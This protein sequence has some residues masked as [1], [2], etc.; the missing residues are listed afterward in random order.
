[1]IKTAIKHFIIEYCLHK[2]MHFDNSMTTLHII[3]DT[4]GS[5][6]FFLIGAKLTHVNDFDGDDSHI[7]YEYEHM[8][9]IDEDIDVSPY[10]T[11]REHDNNSK[12]VSIECKYYNHEEFIIPVMNKDEYIPYI[13]KKYMRSTAQMYMDFME[14]DGPLPF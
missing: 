13:N 4:H 11:L 9:Y 3:Y 10:Y 8:F 1:M 12:A 2:L 14:D 5:L 7:L 6:E